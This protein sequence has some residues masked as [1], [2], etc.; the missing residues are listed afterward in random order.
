MNKG[1]TL[2]ELAI[3]LAVAA[4]IIAGII[5]TGDSVFGRA[6]VTS[7]LA[8][9]KDLATASREFKVRY[10]HFPGDLPKAG[11]YITGNGGLSG[12][13]A[14][15][16]GTSIGDGLVNSS[17]ESNCAVEHLVKANMLTKAEYDSAAARYYIGVLGSTAESISLWFN[18]ETNENVV[19][20]RNVRCEVAQEMERKLDNAT[21]DNTPF[22]GG[23]V[24]ARD[25][26]DSVIESCSSGG[27]ND[28]VP[29]LLI[30]Y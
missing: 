4:I 23:A 28:P 20:I 26:A 6:G 8:N 30:K 2:I 16:N 18:S 1:F 3:V 9:T 22:K 5:V 19:R 10:G 27:T 12:V 13:C 17:T 25:A 15:D 24:T 29:N 11:T 21:I 14:N 7:L